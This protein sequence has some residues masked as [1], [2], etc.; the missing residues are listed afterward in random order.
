MSPCCIYS[1]LFRSHFNVELKDCIALGQSCYVS[2]SVPELQELNQHFE[3]SLQVHREKLLVYQRILVDKPVQTI[4]FSEAYTRVKLRNSLT[5]QYSMYGVQGFGKIL[6]I[7]AKTFAMLRTLVSG[8]ESLQQHFHSRNDCLDKIPTD[9]GLA[10]VK[11]GPVQ[12]IQI[13]QIRSVIL[14]LLIIFSMLPLYLIINM[15][16]NNIFCVCVSV[17]V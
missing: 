5:V 2:P 6:H 16:I 12:C 8:D 7:N 11:E 1:F 17:C 14:L 3:S 9:Y 10:V 13:S 4:L 15:M